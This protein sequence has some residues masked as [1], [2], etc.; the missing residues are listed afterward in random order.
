[1]IQLAAISRI[2]YMGE[3][4]VRAL[5]QVDLTILPGEYVSIM[6]PSG[7]G[8]ST[9][10]NVIGL[11]D[12]PDSGQYLLNGKNVTD[13]SE[14]EQAKVRREKIG[15][16]FQSF[17]LVPRMTAA[18]NIELPLTLS[19]IPLSERKTRVLETLQSFNLS[20][21]AQHRPAEL[22]GGQR[23]RVAIARAT[24]MRPTAILADEPTGNLD[25]R[26]GAEVMALLE[27]LHQGG[28]TLLIVTHDRELGLR[29][30]RKIGMRDGRI[31]SDT[32]NEKQ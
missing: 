9:L 4:A 8:K 17:H 25:H 14:T 30:Q 20:D 18:E 28:T 23:Q 5:D 26:I 12:R 21:R 31:E 29:A 24:I 19:G 22:S 15:F 7:S 1:M 16:V 13:L 27:A 10:L 6:G 2:F 32:R 3:Q 11:L